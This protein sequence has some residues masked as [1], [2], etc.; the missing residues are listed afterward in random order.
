M[1][2]PAKACLIRFKETTTKK[3][4]F[5]A[6][7]EIHGEHLAFVHSDRSVAALFVMDTVESWSEIEFK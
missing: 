2:S 4:V 5:A 1:V 3:L 6:S 7:V